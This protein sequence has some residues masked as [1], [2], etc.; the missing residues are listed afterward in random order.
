[1][2]NKCGA[3]EVPNDAVAVWWRANAAAVVSRDADA[4]DGALVLLHLLD[5]PRQKRL[6][7]RHQMNDAAQFLLVLWSEQKTLS[8]MNILYKF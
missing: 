6:P 8:N 3:L 4:V 5:Q 7:L 2:S 1:M